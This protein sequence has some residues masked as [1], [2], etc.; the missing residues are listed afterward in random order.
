MP[1]IG[2]AGGPS[3][4]NDK[5]MLR[6]YRQWY[7]KTYATNAIKTTLHQPNIFARQS[8]DYIPRPQQMR[9]VFNWMN[10]MSRRNE[11]SAQFYRF[12]CLFRL[13]YF[14]LLLLLPMT[15]LISLTVSLSTAFKPIVA[16][17]R[18]QL[19]CLYL[20][21]ILKTVLKHRYM[22]FIF[23]SSQLMGTGLGVFECN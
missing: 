2:S 9:S 15:D 22:H 7:L 5:Y 10:Q 13:Q 23:N 11:L 1:I 20:H 6:T 14:K 17:A 18:N 19:K 12:F 4:L 3:K 21:S 8:Y 16:N